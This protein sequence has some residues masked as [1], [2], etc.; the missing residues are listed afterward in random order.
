MAEN[1]GE[2][3]KSIEIQAA[4]AAG[5]VPTPEPKPAPP[6]HRPNGRLLSDEAYDALGLPR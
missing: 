6:T 2:K 4:I 5:W 1:K 3:V